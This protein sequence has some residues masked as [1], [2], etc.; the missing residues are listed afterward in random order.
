MFLFRYRPN[1]LLLHATMKLSCVVTWATSAVLVHYQCAVSQTPQ[2]LSLGSHR[3]G[4]SAQLKSAG[5][6]TLRAKYRS[7]AAAPSTLRLSSGC[8][9][10]FSQHQG[11]S[12]FPH[13]FTP[14]ETPTQGWTTVFALARLQKTCGEPLKYNKGGKNVLNP[15]ISSLRNEKQAQVWSCRNMMEACVLSVHLC[16]LCWLPP[17]QLSQSAQ[18]NIDSALPSMSRSQNL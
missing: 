7:T 8:F 18:Q 4:T 3:S 12:E 6:F 13:T 10:F 17:T 1:G 9:F 14:R 11:F 15:S 5:K 16:Y 2:G